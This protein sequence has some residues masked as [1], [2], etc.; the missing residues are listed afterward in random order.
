MTIIIVVKYLIFDI[1]LFTSFK[2]RDEC[3]VTV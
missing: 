2:L 1:T 3:D